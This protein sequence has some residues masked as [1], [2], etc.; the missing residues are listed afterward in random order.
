LRFGG[1]GRNFELVDRATGEVVN[2]GRLPDPVQ[3]EISMPG[4]NIRIEGGTFNAG[5]SFLI[6]PTR[7]AAA[8]IGLEVNREEDLAFASPV[9]AEG[10][11]GNTGDATINQGKM[12]D[13]R[14]P[15]TNSL[16]SNFR[17]DGQ[18]DPP[19][20]IQFRDDGGQ[21][22]YDI[23]DANTN[24]VLQAGDAAAVP[25]VNVFQAGQS[26]KL[27]TEDPRSPDYFGFQ[28]EISGNPRPGDS[29]SI[30]Y[31]T[32]GVSDNRNAEFLAA[33]GTENTLN[34]G[35][36]SFAEGYA[37]LVEDIGVKTRQSQLDK[38]AGSTLLEQS[39]N[40]RES[41]SGVNLDEE[42][43]KLI[44]YQAAYNASAQVVSVAQDLFNT[45]LQSFR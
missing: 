24:T 41:V 39:T 28:F 25:P 1:D 38:D 10:S 37:G 9:R 22:V 43:G 32:N 4:F 30:N 8:N 16:L 34:N 31:N 11:A 15:F 44:Q 17:Q 36:Q 29:F 2:Q 21:L 12:L 19:L 7:N 6:E 35:S 40:Q 13:V 20:D 3:S 18:L 26:N 42:A 27:F 33:L 23:V 14:D 5:D 45:L